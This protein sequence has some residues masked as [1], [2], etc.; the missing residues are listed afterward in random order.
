MW[1]RGPTMTMSADRSASVK[2]AALFI[3][4]SGIPLVTLGWLGGRLLAQD[5]AL[6]RV[7]DAA[8]DAPG[9]R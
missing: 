1:R 6:E 7:H 9:S 2:L 5:R 4:L 3:V 8:A